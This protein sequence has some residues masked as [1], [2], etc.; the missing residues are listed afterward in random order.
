VCRPGRNQARTFTLEE[1]V[2]R[3]ADTSIRLWRYTT[4]LIV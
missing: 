4:S 2:T 1:V 3:R